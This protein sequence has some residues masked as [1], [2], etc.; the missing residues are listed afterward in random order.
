MKRII[1]H[2][3][4]KG[5]IINEPEEQDRYT[6][7]LQ[8]NREFYSPFPNKKDLIITEVLEI[9][10]N[11]ITKQLFKKVQYHFS[12]AGAGVTT[13]YNC[14]IDTPPTDE[15]LKFIGESKIDY[16]KFFN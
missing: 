16:I 13:S 1:V 3:Y 12:G 9:D 7:L 10:K 5:V 8:G 4:D 11:S 14:T 6:T 2:N 15:Q